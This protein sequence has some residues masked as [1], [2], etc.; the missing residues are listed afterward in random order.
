MLPNQLVKLF[1][2]YLSLVLSN[3]S[4]YAQNI[5]VDSLLKL[6]ST[7]NP[8]S[9][10]GRIYYDLARNTYASDTKNALL[11]AKQGVQYF[12]NTESHQLL[13]RCM[14]LEAVCLFI[15]DKHEESIKL[16][17]KI[18][19]IREE[20]KDTLGIAETLLNIGNNYYR[21]QD[22]EQAVKF[23]HKS[24]EYALKSNNVKLLAGL[25]NNLG[26][27]YKDK[28]S[29]NKKIKDKNL[30]IKHLKEAILYKEKLK[31]D[32]TLEK[33]YTI[34]AYVYF[35]SKDYKTAQLYAT[36]A[37]QYAL[38]HKNGEGVGSSKLL[39]AKIAVINKE[40]ELAQSILD[41][42]YVFLGQNKAFH[43]LNMH[44]DEIIVLRNMIRN[45]RSNTSSTLDSLNENNY[46]K[47]L[48][49]RQKVREELNIQY[50]TEKKDLENANLTLKNKITQDNLHKTRV[51]TTISI[52]FALVL[53]FLVIKLRNKNIALSK[54]EQE[55]RKQANLVHQQNQLLKQSESFKTKLFSI[56]SHD[57]KSPINSLKIIVD[58]S[59][60][61]KLSNSDYSYLM[62]NLKKELHVTSN[63]LNDLLFWSKSQMKSNS[64]KWSHFNLYTTIQKTENTLSSSIKL[65]QLQI[66]NLIPNDFEIYGD[67]MRFEF[68]VRN[69]LHNAIKYSEF[70][71]QIE[72]GIK[73]KGSEIDFYIR[74][75]GVGMSHE[76]VKKMFNH[77]RS[78]ISSRGTL[79][80]QGAGI[81]LLLCH[82]FVESLGWTLQV[83]S[84]IG[85]GTIFHICIPMEKH[86]EFLSDDSDIK[87]DS[88]LQLH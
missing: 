53:L 86:K 74:D 3:S 46:N 1:L 81:G 22:L 49:S 11:W 18:L 29:E 19:K 39:L 77:D 42:L 4:S 44:D 8:D 56:I 48:L 12:E 62:D 10:N 5:N 54:S 45:L 87:Q 65:K 68:I 35:E 82:D 33:T 32:R 64:I 41:G 13:T 7:N 63:L 14:N 31:T 20:K 47:L 78:R 38:T 61:Q 73:N 34:L 30:A 70:Y 57:L 27:Y 51:I 83:E 69:I 2:V 67:E 17:Y 6:V 40:H 52:L 84:T 75:N 43:I 55:I 72:V 15:L 16:H 25:N 79:D 60:E 37:E 80:E 9:T 58:M 59:V 76:Q 66:K 28:F 23:Y 50:E 24:R 71:K 36:K 88:Y 85:Q 26:N 21:G